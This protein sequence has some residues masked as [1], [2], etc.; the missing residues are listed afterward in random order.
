M[1]ALDFSFENRAVIAA[2]SV[3]HASRYETLELAIAV[4]FGLLLL[5]FY[6]I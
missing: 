6:S 1:I 3:M 4:G 5:T 2:R